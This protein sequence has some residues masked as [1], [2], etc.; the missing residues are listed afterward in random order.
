VVA[1][2]SDLAALHERRASRVSLDG[3]TL[4]EAAQVKHKVLHNR[5]RAQA[6]QRRVG[7]LLQH[8]VAQLALATGGATGAEREE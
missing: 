3:E 2:A 8:S 6:E 7:A 1:A 5:G 4:P